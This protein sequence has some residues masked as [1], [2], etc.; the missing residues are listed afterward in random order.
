VA[1]VI[2]EAPLPQILRVGGMDD[3][4]ALAVLRARE[5]QTLELAVVEEEK[6]LIYAHAND[7][8][9]EM[10]KGSVPRPE[11]GRIIKPLF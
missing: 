3:P 5:V 2:V 7:Y 9:T 6:A 10:R 4:G 1:I 8:A 11:G